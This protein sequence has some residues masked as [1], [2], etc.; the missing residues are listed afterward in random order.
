MN[1]KKLLR[2]EKITA[3]KNLLPEE[4]TLFSHQ[5]SEKLLSS[6][7]YKHTNTIMLYQAIPGEVNLSEFAQIAQIHGK[8]LF[9]PQCTSKTEMIS[10]SPR[11]NVWSTGAFGI[12]EPNPD[13]SDPIAP[14]E[15]DLVICPCASFDETCNRLGMGAGYYDR[16]LPKCTNAHIIAV[17][18]EVQKTPSVPTNVWDRPMEMII[19]ERKIYMK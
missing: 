18:F 16:F 2:Q 17:A 15:L 11:D 7:L 13:F 9:Y 14:A 6:E 1:N 10:L 3:R 4:R 8:Q 5:I 12:R 19:T